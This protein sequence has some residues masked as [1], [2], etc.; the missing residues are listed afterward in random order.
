MGTICLVTIH[1]IGFE[2]PPLK[3]ADGGPDTPGYADGLHEHLSEYLNATKLS[4]DPHREREQDGENGPI[5]VQSVWPPDSHCLED[6]LK[7]LGTWDEEHL[8]TIDGASA[9]LSKGGARLA[10]IA[11]VYSQAEDH[12]AQLGA[13][14][15]AGLMALPMLGHYATTLGLVRMLFSDIQPLLPHHAATQKKPTNL[16]P[17]HDS[18]YKRHR[19]PHAH[20]QQQQQQQQQNP[21][22]QDVVRQLEDDVAGYVCHNEMRE[23]VRGFVL[24][25]LL[26]LACRDD[27][28]GIVI[29]S[30]SN[31]TVVAIDVLR[32]L[33][34]FAAKKILALIT[35]GSPLRKYI[36]C[37]TWG[38]HLATIPRIGRW[39]NF[40]DERDPVGDPLTPP[41]TWRRG[42][43]IKAQTGL[44]KALDPTTGQISDLDIEDIPIDNVTNSLGGGLQAHNYWDNHEEFVQPLAIF[45]HKLLAE[46][47]QEENA[48]AKRADQSPE[49]GERGD[50]QRS[51][52]HLQYVTRSARG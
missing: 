19:T 49:Y 6:G 16:C 12:G 34:P 20:N 11:L 48:E 44:F 38:E 46:T 13:A 24:D 3:G 47:S 42:T 7:R 31:G 1:G 5:Y 35:A 33:P 10:H 39:K 21:S 25:A 15:I 29:N 30:H 45:L 2:Q 18:G 36:D 27:V 43:P 26:R 17:R 9:P 50:E 32:M 4:D 40:Y 22:F 41:S 28:D 23:R 51:E 37:F 52:A 14:A 8:R